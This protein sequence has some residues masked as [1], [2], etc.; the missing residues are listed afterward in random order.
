MKV[1]ISWSGERSKEVAR[2]LRS[3]I[4][5]VLQSVE[6]WMSEKDIGAGSLWLNEIMT[7][8]EDT[9]FCIVC[10]TP[11][12]QKAPWLH[13]EAGAIA[14]HITI[15]RVCPYLFS[16]DRSQFKDNPLTNFQYKRADEKGTKEIIESINREM[17]KPISLDLLNKNFS[18]WWPQLDRSLSDIPG[19]DIEPESKRSS[20]SI[21]EEVLELTR[22]MS[23]SMSRSRT[24]RKLISNLLNV[25]SPK[26]ERILKMIYGLGDE[27]AHSYEE[28]GIIFGISNGEVKDIEFEAIEKLIKGHPKF[29]KS[30]YDAIDF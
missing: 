19:L 30:I 5:G 23:R 13:F 8:L 2:A 24:N 11:E 20:E 1:F 28:V 27:H 25:L 26:E 16:L 7:E 12:N 17:E 22:Q 29:M 14:K 18:L 21:L 4:P 15:S 9:G 10:I 6:P 3:W